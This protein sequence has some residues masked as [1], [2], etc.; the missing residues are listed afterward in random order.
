MCCIVLFPK[1]KHCRRH[2]PVK[3]LRR[4]GLLPL[5]MRCHDGWLSDG[6]FSSHHT[7]CQIALSRDLKVF[8]VY[9][10]CLVFSL[11]QDRFVRLTQLSYC[12]LYL[13]NYGKLFIEFQDLRISSS[14]SRT[15]LTLFGT[16]VT[17]TSFLSLVAE[18]DRLQICQL[19]IDVADLFIVHRLSTCCR[20][21]ACRAGCREEFSALCK[22]VVNALEQTTN[23][24]HCNWPCLKRW[25]SYKVSYATY[26]CENFLFSITIIQAFCT[27]QSPA[28]RQPK[29]C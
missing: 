12:T 20:S 21:L 19:T 26:C 13:Q 11:C 1:Q 17:G 23:R 14:S 9:G 29:A 22:R 10:C 24:L 18:G 7:H 4:P 16:S 15:A 25:I 5:L 27:S 28:A 8:R 3:S 6:S 2:W